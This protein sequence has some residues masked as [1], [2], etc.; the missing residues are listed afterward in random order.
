MPHRRY[1]GVAFLY[2]VVLRSPVFVALSQEKDLKIYYIYKYFTLRQLHPPHQYAQ[3]IDRIAE[4]AYAFILTDKDTP[5]RVAWEIALV[6]ED[7]RSSRHVEQN[8]SQGVELARRVH[9][10]LVTPLGNA[11]MLTRPWWFKGVA[12]ELAVDDHP[13]DDVLLPY[14]SS[15]YFHLHSHYMHDVTPSVVPIAVRMAMTS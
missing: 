4:T 6:D 7:S 9:L 1:P 14:P 13:S 3:R 5:L 11:R 10:H 8:G 15:F 2:Y 12:E